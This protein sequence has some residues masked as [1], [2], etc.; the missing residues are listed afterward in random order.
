M[1]NSRPPARRADAKEPDVDRLLQQLIDTRQHAWR[2]ELRRQ[3]AKLTE[4]R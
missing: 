3:L 2:A 4:S 1:E